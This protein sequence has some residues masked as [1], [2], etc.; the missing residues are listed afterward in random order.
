M[1][2]L[3]GSEDLMERGE[4]HGK[5]HEKELVISKSRGSS[6]LTTSA[7]LYPSNQE[8]GTLVGK[9]SSLMTRISGLT[10]SEDSN[11]NPRRRWLQRFTRPLHQPPN[12]L[13]PA[14]DLGIEP[15]QAITRTCI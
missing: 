7:T 14:K 8:P 13:K 11:K 6:N 1:S 4:L 5:E 2:T 15:R 9:S 12:A 3:S 10:W